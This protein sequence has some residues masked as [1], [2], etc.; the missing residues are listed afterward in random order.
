MFNT[1]IENCDVDLLEHQKED[2]KHEIIYGENSGY[3]AVFDIEAGCRKTR[4]AEEALVDLY[5]K[6]E[7]ALLVRR[8]DIDCRESMHNINRLAKKDISFAYNNEDVTVSNMQRVNKTLNSIPIIII[9]HQKYAVL[10]K[11]MNKRKLFA[12]CRRTLVIDEFLSTINVISLGESDIET[13]R[14]ILDS[15]HVLLQAFEKAMAEPIDFLKTWNKEKSAVRKFVTLSDHSP[16]KDFNELIKL[17]HSN[18]TNERLNDLKQKIMLR[19][20]NL[21]KPIDYSLLSELSTIKI[22]CDKILSYKQ[23]FTSMCVY[24]GKK[25]FTTNKSFKYW[26]LDNNIMLDASGELQIAYSLNHNEFSLRHCEKVLDHRKWKIINIP[27]TTTTSG[28]DKISNF[29]DVVNTRIKKYGDDI[30]VIGKKDEMHLINS[31]DVNKGYFGNITGS[32]QWHN[33]KHVAI[34]QT[35]NL[36]D[37]DYILKYLHYAK[38]YIDEKFPLSSKCSG[39]TGRRIYGFSN[40]ELENIRVHWIASEMYQA[41]KRVNRNMIYDTEVLIFMNNEK[42][43]SLLKAQMQNC[44][45]EI[46]DY[47]DDIFTFE[48]SKQDDYVEI[49]KK[50]SYASK[51]IDLLAETQNGIHPDLIDKE[52]RIPKIKVREFLGIKTSGNFSNKVLNKSDVISYCKARDIDLNGKYIKLSRNL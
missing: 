16:A 51:F 22:F 2:L 10:M 47:V 36:N 32:N 26:F 43:I 3:F 44:T 30:L 39:T 8:T 11:D 25:L 13:Y 52:G 17:I 40:P 37:V 7:S 15:D 38:E 42:I 27:V 14:S 48:K 31:Q 50:D 19:A 28:K 49:L 33:K 35:H 4:T 34:I 29:Y 24:I 1:K 41:I 5:K 9:T 45:V 21:D 46:E 20:E 12:Q 18:M 6:G 23:I